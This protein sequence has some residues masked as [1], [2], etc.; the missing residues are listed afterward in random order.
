MAYRAETSADFKNSSDALIAWISAGNIEDSVMPKR[1]GD[2]VQRSKV[3]KMTSFVRQRVSQWKTWAKC[4]RMDLTTLGQSTSGIS[5]SNFAVM[6]HGK[7]TVHA[8]M[9][10]DRTVD[11]VLRQERL[12]SQKSVLRS[13]QLRSVALPSATR[14]ASVT[15]LSQLL[16][17]FATRSLDKQYILSTNYTY[18]R[19]ALDK[20]LV[21]N[22]SQDD[23]SESTDEAAEIPWPK[24]AYQRIVT[25]REA[26]CS[27]LVDL[28]STGLWRVDIFYVLKMEKFLLVMRISGIVLCG[29]RVWFQLNLYNERMPTWTLAPLQMASI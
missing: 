9:E 1:K 13:D 10:I 6:K 11:V 8:Q 7:I 24:F 19:I 3:D 26:D 16:T 4:A 21:P 29:K 2:S 5:E 15:R 28:K 14:S 20:W 23:V 25:L 18:V 27:V 12:Q 22:V 17:A